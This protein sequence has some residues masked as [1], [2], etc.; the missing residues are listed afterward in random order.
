MAVKKIPMRMCCGCG[1]M[2]PKKELIRVVRTSENE[3]K[4]DFTGRLNGRSAQY[5]EY[6][7]YYQQAQYLYKVCS[8]YRKTKFESHII[9]FTYRYSIC[10]I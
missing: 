7:R 1:E 4:L 9:Y 3:V 8:Y 6:F 5:R 2:K 10:K